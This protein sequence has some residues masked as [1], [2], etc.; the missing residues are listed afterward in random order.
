[1]VKR[2]QSKNFI[3]EDY[4]KRIAY[5]G[6]PA[7][8]V[9]TLAALMRCQL[10]SIAFENLDVQAG[11]VVSM[12]PEDIVEKII[13][14][15]RGGYCYEVNGLF[16]MALSALGFE[17]TLIGARPMFYPARRPKTHMVLVVKLD[18]Q[19]WL[20]DLGFG[21]FGIR[22]P[23]ALDVLDIALHQDDDFFKLIKTD[24]KNFIMQALV[25]G[26][27]VSQYGFDLYAQEWIDFFPANFLNSKHPDAI[28]VQKLLVVK[29]NPMGRKSLL[30]NRLKKIEKGISEIKD[31]SDEEVQGVLRTEFGLSIEKN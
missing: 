13:Y 1:M 23:L 8:N 31:L 7:V 2:V 17:Y 30:G 21:S 5:Q 6:S 16:A 22:A 9:K 4:F 19:Q 20:C 25:D 3:L 14:N 11:K 10:F 18:D 28:F 26:E 29:H 15:N 27:W 12:V 24:A